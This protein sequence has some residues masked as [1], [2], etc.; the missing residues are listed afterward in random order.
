MKE[1]DARINA[2]WIDDL[3][4]DP[5]S[6][7][8]FEDLAAEVGIDIVNA[9]NVEEGIRFL[10]NP[11]YQFDAIILDINCYRNSDEG[12]VTESSALS[13]AIQQLKEIKCNIPYFVY[14]ALGEGGVTAVDIVI[15]EVN[16]WDNRKIYH[17]TKTKDR[18]DL[19][20]AIKKAVE[21]KEEF[22]IK[23][24]FADAFGV[25]N[26]GTL[27]GLVKSFKSPYFNNDTQFPHKI[28][29]AIEEVANKF[30]SLGL[31]TFSQDSNNHSKELSTFLGAK[32]SS[33]EGRR[34][35]N[36]IVPSYIQ[37]CLHMLS[38]C[39][40]EG[41]HSYDDEIKTYKL[42]FL[43]EQGRAQYVNRI[44]FFEMMQVLA[45][46]KQLPLDNIE[47][48]TKWINYFEEIRTTR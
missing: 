7:N 11:S 42:P 25:I 19:F 41:S 12:A 48:K 27:I 26:N 5:G 38:E 24:Q 23:Q 40:N 37:R 8:S 10:Q 47:W 45:W 36:K 4:S 34:I 3:P 9:T 31:I 2:L 29:E 15:P 46:C 17:K 39:A 32:D 21:N 43:M 6:D 16:P 28:R 30:A 1:N 13:Y 18:N 22:N 33:P 44:L 14:S 35:G 20:D